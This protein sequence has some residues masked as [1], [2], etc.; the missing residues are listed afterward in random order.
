MTIEEQ[1]KGIP[2]NSLWVYRIKEILQEHSK[3]HF[4]C[5]KSGQ[6]AGSVEG[7]P[8]TISKYKT[9]NYGDLETYLTSSSKV[10][11]LIIRNSKKLK[12]VV[13]K[14][15]TGNPHMPSSYFFLAMEI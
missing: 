5:V 15:V 11:E 9:V 12:V 4:W 7:V 3:A 2:T 13:N 10:N 8:Q 14:K 1:I 6:E